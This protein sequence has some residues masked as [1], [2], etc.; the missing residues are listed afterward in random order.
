MAMQIYSLT[1][2]NSET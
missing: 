2:V 1:K